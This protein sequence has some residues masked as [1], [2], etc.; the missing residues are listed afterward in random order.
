MS[1]IAISFMEK[2][3]IE[4]SARVLSVAMTENPIHL[5]VFQ[6]SNENV[7]IE[8]ENYFKK[9]LSDKP[10]IVFIAKANQNIIG[11]VRMC[12]CYGKNTINDTEVSIDETNIDWRRDIWIN[13]WSRR[14]PKDQ[15]WH[16][17]PIG[18]LPTHQGVGVGSMLME[19]FC[20]EV[21]ACMAN[22][23]L[24][25]DKDVNVVFYQKFGFKTISESMIF[26]VKNWYMLRL[27]RL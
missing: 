13:E 12:S 7:R 4:E 23:Y 8:I 10:G 24:E 11:V 20:S 19:R 3:D 17:G 21:D 2:R 25:T 6:N 26:G 27:S 18:V 16:L 14:D 5:A 1:N 22:A 9:L 15:H